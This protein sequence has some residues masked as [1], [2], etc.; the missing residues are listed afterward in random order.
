MDQV[1][2]CSFEDFI[3]Q[4]ASLRHADKQRLLASGA[5]RHLGHSLSQVGKECGAITGDNIVQLV[6]KDRGASRELRR[7]G[8]ILIR[9]FSHDSQD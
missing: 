1:T 3:Y 4:L 5:P 8:V 2:C 7:H 6:P 9:Q